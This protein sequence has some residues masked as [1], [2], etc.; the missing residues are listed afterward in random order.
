MVAVWLWRL[1][2]WQVGVGANG[3][4]ILV[5]AVVVVFYLMCGPRS[6]ASGGWRVV[7]A[8]VAALRSL[9]GVGL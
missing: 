7:F 8:V 5:D 4:F 2:K 1:P 3:R 9:V 6:F